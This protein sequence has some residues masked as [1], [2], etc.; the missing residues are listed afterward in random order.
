M[1]ARWVFCFLNSYTNTTPPTNTKTPPP[2]FLLPLSL[3]TKTRL[4]LSRSRLPP[5]LLQ[6]PQSL[7]PDLCSL[8]GLILPFDLGISCL[9]VTNL[10]F[11]VH[12]DLRSLPLRIKQNPNGRLVQLLLG[13]S[14]ECRI[15][16]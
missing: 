13:P 4:P 12:L 15:R 14:D 1:V 2:D 6:I 8:S 9:L 3:E 10:L 11:Q 7:F 16:A 5:S